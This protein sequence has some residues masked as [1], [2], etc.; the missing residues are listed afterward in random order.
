MIFVNQILC[1]TGDNPHNDRILWIDDNSTIAYVINILNP[2]SLPEKRLVA[3]LLSDLDEGFAAIQTEDILSNIVDDDTLT[4]KEI[5]IR[6][7]RW[8]RIKDFVY[9]EPDIYIKSK[10][11]KLLEEHC[12]KNNISPKEIYKLLKLYWF[13]GKTINALIPEYKNSGGKGKSKKLTNKKNG[14]RR[15]GNDIIGDG[16]VIDEGIEHIFKASAEKYYLNTKENTLTMVYDLMLKDYFTDRVEIED[17]NVVYK[18]RP[19]EELPSINQFRYWINNKYTDKEKLIR[20]K[21]LRNFNL[22]NRAVLGSSTKGIIGPGSLYQID[23][24]IADVYLVSRYNRTH[25]IGRPVVYFVIDVFSRMITGVYCGLE[26]PSWAGAMMALSNAASDKVAFCDSYGISIS[27]EDWD[28]AYIPEAILGDRGEMESKKA[29]ALISSLQIR[30]ENNPPYRG[31][32]KGIVEQQFNLI[33]GKIK[34]FTPGFVEKDHMTRTGKDYR[35]DAKLDLYQFTQIIINCILIHN[36]THWLKNYDLNEFLI[37]EE[38]DCIPS[39]LWRWG[40]KNRSGKLRTVDEDKIK[41]YL[42]PSSIASV[43]YKGIKFKNIYYSCDIAIKEHWFEKARQKGSW[44]VNIAFDERNMNNI[45][46]KNNDNT[47]EVCYLLEANKQYKNKSLYEIDYE[48]VMLETRRLKHEHREKEQKIN[49]Y[50]KIESIVADAVT[51]TNSAC[52]DI[53]LSNKDKVS[54]I[55]VNR[56]VEKDLNREDERFSIG[57]NNSDKE[58]SA[59]RLDNATNHNVKEEDNPLYELLRRK[60]KEGLNNGK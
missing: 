26:G 33:N 15:N 16:I 30:I 27:K 14:R 20:R 3:E 45:Y 31:D 5:L 23:A 41:L 46:I 24:T 28:T 50:S 38:I 39:T 35:L 4:D 22:K 13:K 47:F 59:I 7:Q 9:I 58:T 43:T 19:I 29:E 10:R 17:G 8:D 40:I 36:N 44:K 49:F 6:S 52:S 18:L 21:G 37:G 1:Y 32:W 42:M 12:T 51:E 57:V 60:Q 53:I 56:K 48:R 54:S 55:K 34:P 2:K 25:I 11:W